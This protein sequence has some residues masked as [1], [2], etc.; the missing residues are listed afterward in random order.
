[1]A[2]DSKKKRK[3][4]PKIRGQKKLTRRKALSRLNGLIELCTFK[5]DVKGVTIPEKMKWARILNNSIKNATPLLRDTDLDA[6]L[7]RLDKVEAELDR[8]S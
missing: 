3:S 4:Q 8:R 1:M 5:I 6:L 7:A 2:S